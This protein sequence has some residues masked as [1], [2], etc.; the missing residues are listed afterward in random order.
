MCFTNTTFPF[1]PSNKICI[2]LYQCCIHCELV[3]RHWGALIQ[4]LA[5]NKHETL[6][7]LNNLQCFEN[8]G[9]SFH[10][11]TELYGTIFLSKHYKC[12]QGKSECML[13][14]GIMIMEHFLHTG[15]DRF[16]S[17]GWCLRRDLCLL[18]VRWSLDL[19]ICHSETIHWLLHVHMW[20]HL[21]QSSRKLL[22]MLI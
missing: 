22:K 5:I 8:D 7:L 1:L 21:W 9:Y 17:S 6:F 18:V 19:R 12:T 16:L 10:Y 4:L 3:H 13:Y 11:S 15:N 20:S 14:L 2:W